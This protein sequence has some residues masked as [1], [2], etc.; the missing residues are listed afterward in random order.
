MNNP[1]YEIPEEPKNGEVPGFD[2][3]AKPEVDHLKEELARGSYQWTNKFTKILLSA[4]IVVSLLSAGAWYGHRSAASVGT[5]GVNGATGLTGGFGA[6]FGNR[7]NSATGSA[8]PSGAPD[9]NVGG[10]GGGNR[11]TGKVS[12]V[13]GSSVTITLD[14]QTQAE[15]I[16]AGDTMRLT[17]TGGGQS[18]RVPGPA[19][20]KATT[21]PS[22]KPTIAVGGQG[23]GQ[24]QT[25]G[26]GRFNNPELTACL[27]K[28]GVV[29]EPGSRPDRTDPKVAAAMQKCFPA[30]GFG[31]P[32]GPGSQ[33]SAPK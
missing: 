13:S 16:K 21:V 17:T 10:F 9:A 4:L 27:A 12:K 11:I 23:Q 24:G 2:L 25:G 33:S 20:S 3:F 26:G 19:T 28:E 18:G 8:A 6:G 31:G 29:I 5:S 22:A 30:A 7:N 14:D 15:S 1:T 32:G